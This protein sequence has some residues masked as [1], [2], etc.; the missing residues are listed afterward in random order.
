MARLRH[1]ID[2]NP[3]DNQ[4][5]WPGDKTGLESGVG[6]AQ[7]LGKLAHIADNR[8]FFPKQKALGLVRY[9]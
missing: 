4:L 8:H 2:A 3:L 9:G 1:Y 5:A 7:M 6:A